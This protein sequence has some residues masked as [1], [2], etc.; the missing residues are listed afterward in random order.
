M[1]KKLRCIGAL[2]LAVLMIAGVFGVRPAAAADTKLNKSTAE[3]DAYERMS[4]K[5]KSS[6]EGTYYG[7]YVQKLNERTGE[8]DYAGEA[9]EAEEKGSGK[10]SYVFYESGVYR[11]TIYFYDADYY[12]HS[13]SCTVTVRGVGPARRNMAVIVG[14]ETSIAT[15]N[16]VFERAEVI[17]DEN[18]WY[19]WYYYT[20]S[21]DGEIKIDGNKIKG[22]KEG[23]VK[24]RVYYRPDEG[25]EL[26]SADIT[27]HVTDP[28]YTPVDGYRL[29]GWY[30]YLN[31]TGVSEYSDIS[32]TCDNESV[33]VWNGGYLDIV[34][35]GKCKV[36]IVA[37]GREFTD[38]I[39][40]YA[41]ECSDSILLLKKKKSR[42]IKVTGLPEG[43]KVHYSSADKKIATVSADGKVK[44][45]AAGS[46]SITV[47][48][49]DLISFTCFVTVSKGG[50]AFTAAQKAYGFIGGKY[51][52][53]K[54][55][56]DGYFDCS[57]LVWRAYKAAGYDLAGEKKY[58][59]TAADLAK[60]LEADGKAIAYEYI[61]PSE[62]RPGDLIFYS[63]GLNGR[64]KNIDHVAMYYAAGNAGRYSGYYDYY[65]DPTYNEGVMVHATSPS[66]H[67][68]SYSGY[69]PY[70]IVMICRPID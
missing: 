23:R 13:A 7:T 27:V 54:R 6:Y 26:T 9:Y 67:M 21:Y 65:N 35:A 41:P 32:V 24:V 62:L 44:G 1:G 58:A 49:G 64:Y 61:D 51:S 68:V 47:Q 18:D 56:E 16:A 25:G 48:C 2:L 53:D 4:L 17:E 63:S 20:R 57:A 33:C 55:M 52:Q 36:T 60:K 69:I 12:D 39:E 15:E 59:P 10:F 28:V 8:Y 66:V 50:T 29:A 70:R 19:Y 22:V 43:I 40:A 37:D 46:T 11:V 31:L 5:I 45:K 30:E 14:G 3:V 34:G 38:T 42:Q